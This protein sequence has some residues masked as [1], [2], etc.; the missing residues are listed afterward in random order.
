GDDDDDDVVDAALI[1][2]AP[3]DASADA[4]DAALQ[5][6]SGPDAGGPVPT[7]FGAT[8]TGSGGGYSIARQDGL[9]LTNVARLGLGK[10][11]LLITAGAFT[12]L[13]N[14][15]LSGLGGS[16]VIAFETA[17]TTAFA[18]VRIERADNRQQIDADFSIVCTSTSAPPGVSTRSVHVTQTAGVYGIARS[19]GPWVTVGGSGTG[20]VDLSFNTANFPTRP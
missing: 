13:P 17:P 2:A 6:D 5:P 18:D 12:G 11:R 10:P 1:D 9:W 20:R 19:D 3:A 7:V 4:T 15:V 14:C 8:I 16:F